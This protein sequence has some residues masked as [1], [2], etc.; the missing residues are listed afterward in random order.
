MNQKKKNHSLK[1]KAHTLHWD[2]LVAAH[3]SYTVGLNA[4]KFALLTFHQILERSSEGMQWASNRF[5]VN[6]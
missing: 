1:S 3:C 4:S 2:C 5:K 6:K